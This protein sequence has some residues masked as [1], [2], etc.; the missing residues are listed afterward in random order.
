MS[1]EGKPVMK[2]AANTEV[3][4]SLYKL[5]QAVPQRVQASVVRPAEAVS[6]VG[7]NK[8]VIDTAKV[9][10]ALA[11]INHAMQ[12]SAIGVRF[13]FDRVAEKV[14]TKVVDVESG[15]VLRQMPSEKAIHISQALGKLKGLLVNHSV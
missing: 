6:G 8:P 2:I 10:L 11:E 7:E 12:M 15:E 3:V 9:H 14:V 5:P 13:E 4:S 1:P